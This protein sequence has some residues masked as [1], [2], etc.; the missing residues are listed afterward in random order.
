MVRRVVTMMIVGRG[1]SEASSLLARRSEEPL[2]SS[3]Q[4]RDRTLPDV[5]SLLRRSVL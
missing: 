1:L 5:T 2:L 3:C 4:K